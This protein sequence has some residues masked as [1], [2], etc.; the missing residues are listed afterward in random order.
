MSLSAEEMQKIYREIHEQ[1]I[2]PFPPGTIEERENDPDSKY[3]PVQPYIHRLET[4]AGTFWSWR[5]TGQPV[6]YE[7]EDQVM[8]KGVLKIVD[9]E[10][11]GIGFSNLQRYSDTGKIKNLKYAILSASSDALRNACDLYEMGWKDLSP[12]RKW[13]KNPGTGLSAS[14]FLN[15]DKG[16]SEGSSGRKCIR[17]Q[18]PLTMEDENFLQELQIANDYCRDH[19]PQHLLKNQ[20]KG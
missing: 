15:Q 12:Y 14:A 18:N 4:V 17:C 8:V 20:K 11:E 1:L 6:I 16:G 7:R 3:I 10:R 5:L 2:A 19:I 9:A 13:A